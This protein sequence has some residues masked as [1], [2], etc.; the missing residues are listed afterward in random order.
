MAGVLDVSGWTARAWDSEFFGASI[1]Q[2]TARHSTADALAL[3]V[4][5][6]RQAAI[7][8]L[9]FLVDAEDPA[10][11]RAAEAGGF[12]LVDV[13]LTLECAID[14]PDREPPQ[15]GD[16]AIR[17]ARHEDLQQLMA[18]ARVSHR[19]TR[20]HADTRFDPVRSD[21]LYA[22]WIDRSVR[23]ELADA[24]W[25][26]DVDGSPRGYITASRGASAASIGLVAVDAECRGRGYGDRLLHAV[27]NW[28]RAQGFDRVSVVTQGR[29]AR[30]VRFYER[31]GFTASTV[32]FWYH[33]WLRNV[34]AP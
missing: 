3:A 13:R 22:V 11:V 12:A 26:V 34:Y 10:T 33:R 5:D 21:E 23:G 2:I 1:G 29:S 19:N 15:D 8:C 4:D 28:S 24:V 30:T 27:L 18:L 7:E 25:V 6:A 16:G 17:P 9:Y 32:E 14:G 31:A 20:F